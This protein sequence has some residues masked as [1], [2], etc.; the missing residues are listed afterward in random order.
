MPIT[1]EPVCA[2]WWRQA[3]GPVALTWLSGSEDRARGDLS[4]AEDSEGDGAAATVRTCWGQGPWRARRWSARGEQVTWGRF[5]GS[6]GLFARHRLMQRGLNVAR[7]PL[8]GRVARTVPVGAGPGSRKVTAQLPLP[9]PF[10]KRARGAQGSGGPE[11]PKTEARRPGLGYG[12]ALVRGMVEASRR[13]RG[14]DVVVSLVAG[15]SVHG[16]GLMV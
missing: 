6:W 2:G 1:A 4:R 10:G 15:Q 7:C 3:A 11:K 13:A 5:S 14:T 9:G 8:L 12:R 16:L